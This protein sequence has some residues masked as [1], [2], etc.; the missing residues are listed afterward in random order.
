VKLVY[1]FKSISDEVRT[2][3]L[4]FIRHSKTK[5][6]ILGS[7]FAC[8]AAIFQASGGIF[9]V[10]GYFI[11]PLA[12]APILF[13]SILSIRFGLMSYLLTNLLLLI[14]QPS[15]LIVFPFT[16]GLLGISTGA[17]FYIFKKRL[18]IILCG[19]FVLT[20]GILGLL[21]IFQFPV[22]GP[23]VPGSFSFLTVG[24]IFL[25]AFFYNWIWVELALAFYK[26]VK[27][28]IVL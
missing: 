22:L 5:R 25:F 23:G 1:F 18:S 26:R 17:A 15:E 9:P 19:A 11:S 4:A 10:V 12:T 6:L 13:C 7:I 14:L 24:G 27:K 8:L 20:S 3:H 21:Y 16:T 2:V 28:I